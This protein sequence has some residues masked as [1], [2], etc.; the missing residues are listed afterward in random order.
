MTHLQFIFCHGLSGWGEYDRRYKRIP[1]WGMR[2]GDIMAHL[3]NLGYDCHAASV[4]PKGSAWDRA[5]ELYAQLAGT[6][7]DYGRAHSLK[8]NH[9]RYGRS[10]AAEPLIPEWNDDTRIVLI[11]HSFGGVTVRLLAG[12]LA[13]G[14]EEEQKATYPADTSPLFL[15]GM[16]NRIAAVVTLA[17]P[18]NGT[19]SYDMYLDPGFHPE[20]VK[21]PLKYEMLSKLMRG[22]T[23]VK[24]EEKDARDYADYDMEIDHAMAINSRIHLLPHVYYFSVAC[25]STIR[26][27][28]GTYLPDVSK[29]EGMFVRTSTLM[30]QYKGKTPGGV[31]IGEEWRPNDGLVNVISARAPFNDPRKTFD[32]DR[33]EPGM[34]NILPDY[35]GDHGSLQGGFALKHD[36]RPFYEELTA[37]ISALF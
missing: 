26:Q 12:F 7:V 23:K 5:C 35:D 2:T 32:K 29:T 37:I 30:G 17:A 15:G 33:I 14:D 24:K 28:D 10:F 11:G 13:E 16:G 34:W 18:S 36:P 8:Y 22:S 4:D 19:V 3:R 21:V 9:D 6:R 20:E 31:E 27:P 25:S 1:Y